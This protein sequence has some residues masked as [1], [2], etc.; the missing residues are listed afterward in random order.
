MVLV[1]TATT[2]YIVM[3]IPLF[4]VL[5]Y[6]AQRWGNGWILL[7]YG[8]SVVTSWGLFLTTIQGNFEP[9][10]NYLPFPILLLTVFVGGRKQLSC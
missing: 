3:Y 6:V 7:F 8:V 2:N 4:L 10:I 9:P 1:R 5:K